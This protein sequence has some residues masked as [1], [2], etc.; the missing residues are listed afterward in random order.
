MALTLEII[1]LYLFLKSHTRNKQFD[2]D[3]HWTSIHFSASC[4][5]SMYQSYL[6][7]WKLQKDKQK[8]R[9]FQHKLNMNNHMFESN[10]SE[11]FY[12]FFVFC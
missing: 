12:V 2:E 4:Y 9:Y 5:V 11:V 7:T 10:V 6:S 3:F 8:H 1:I